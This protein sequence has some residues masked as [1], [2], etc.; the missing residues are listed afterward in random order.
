MVQ[1]L[2]LLRHFAVFLA[3]LLTAVNAAY[4]Y[5]AESWFSDRAPRLLLFDSDTG[6][7][8]VIGEIKDSNGTPYLVESLHY[9]E[10]YQL[11]LGFYSYYTGSEARTLLLKIDPTTGAGLLVFLPFLS[12]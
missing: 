9:F 5:T 2:T 7:F 12:P 10:P 1:Q 11:L 3:A 4:F 6:K 8:S